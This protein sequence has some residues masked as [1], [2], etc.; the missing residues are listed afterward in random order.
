[1][2]R[3]TG[4]SCRRGAPIRRG[5]VAQQKVDIAIEDAQGY[6]VLRPSGDLDVY[7]VGSLRDAIGSMIDQK[8]TKVVVDLDGVPFMDSSGL[9][10]LMGGVRRLRE[11]GGD[12]AIACTRE[13]HLKLFTITGFGEGVSIAPTVEEAAKGFKG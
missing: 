8:T 13:Q 1:M 10:A 11:A 4:R 2:S 12:L 6:K 5:T 3:R 7:T 9:G